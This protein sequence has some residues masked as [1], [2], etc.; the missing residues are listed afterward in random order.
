VDFDDRCC[1]GGLKEE[2]VPG[3]EKFEFPKKKEA[4]EKALKALLS[5][6]KK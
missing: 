1:V 4:E 6:L 5:S 2:G 3:T